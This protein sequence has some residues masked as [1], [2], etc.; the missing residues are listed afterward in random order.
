[1]EEYEA[2]ESI[3]EISRRHQVSRQ[4]VHKWIARYQEHGEEGLAELSRA[5]RQH[6]QAVRAEW[7]ERI[8]AARREHRLW[9]APKLEWALKQR[10]GGEAVPSASTIGRVLKETGLS[11]WP[12]RRSRAQGSGDLSGAAEAN[13]VWGIDFKG[14]CRTGDGRR[15]EPLT[16][17]DQASRYIL[18]CQMV[19]STRTEQV[20]PVLEGVFRKYGLPERM[21]SDNGAPFASVGECGLTELSVWWIELGIA[22]ERIKPGHPQQNGRHERMHLTLKEATMQPPA[23]SLRAQQRRFDAFVREFNEHRPHQGLGQKVPAELYRPSPRA[24]PRRIAP[25][26]YGGGWPVR[27]VDEGGRIKW[28]GE[29]FFVSHALSGKLVALEPIGESLWQLWFYGHP[30]G[31]WEG[32]EQRFWRPRQWAAQQA[33]HRPPSSCSSSLQQNG[34]AVQ[35]QDELAALGLDR[36]SV[37]LPDPKIRT[38]DGSEGLLG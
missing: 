8:C 31:V 17:T 15:C 26:E 16:I 28:A 2:G 10:Y 6:P 20:R 36:P 38:K 21:R 13:Q 25:P 11:I 3:A 12:K 37:P 30:L 29:R 19:S 34:G 7:R 22:C 14:W 35:A 33:R 23:G 24:F 1:M 9:G 5:P 18:C 27:R 32:T 4:T